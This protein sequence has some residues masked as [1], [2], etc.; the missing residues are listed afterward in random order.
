MKKQKLIIKAR[1]EDISKKK[2]TKEKEEEREIKI[3]E[4]KKIYLF[5][6][7]LCYIKTEK[8]NYIMFNISIIKIVFF[9]TYCCFPV[10]LYSVQNY[11]LTLR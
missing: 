7:V 2:Q 1:K 4:N 9:T 11:Y 3:L 6:D 5:K 8:R 10:F